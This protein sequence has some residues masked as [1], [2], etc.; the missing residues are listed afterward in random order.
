MRAD[1]CPNHGEQSLKRFYPPTGDYHPQRGFTL[2]EMLVTIFIFTIIATTIFGSYNAVFSNAAAIKN[3]MMAYETAKDCLNRIM[4]D[5]QALYLSQPPAYAPPQNAD[6]QDP[7]RIVGETIY[8]GNSSFARLR[9][10]S[11]AH[12]SMTAKK[13]AGIAEIIYYVRSTRDG[14]Y[15]LRRSDNLVLYGPSEEKEN[16]PVLCENLKSLSFKYY[17]SEG[18]EYEAWDSESEDFVYSTPRAIAVKLAIGHDERFQVFETLIKL[19]YH[20]EKIE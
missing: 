20:R 3:D 2:L 15:T 16:D 10:A 18:D 6:E 9:F 4:L 14:Q 1:R 13:Q 12:L 7:Y 5:L 17:G 8:T 19:P 11:M